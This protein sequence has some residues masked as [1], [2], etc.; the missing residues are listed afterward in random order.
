MK[1][2][3]VTRTLVAAFITTL[4]SLPVAFHAAPLP[5]PNIG[6]NGYYAHDKAQ[7]GRTLQAAIV[8]EIPGGYHV[9]ANRPLG[10]YAIPTSLKIDAP[11]GVNIGPVI[12]PRAIVRRL[13][14]VNNEPLAVYEGRAIL[15]FSVTVPANYQGGEV[16][17]KARLRYQSCND[18]VCFPPATRELDLAIAIV[19]R[20]TPVNHIN[21]QYFGGG[22][23]RRK[24]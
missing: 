10:K 22:G 17:L 24:G 6:V 11:R 14:A 15:R 2:R 21:G 19:G 20:D 5:E 3:N 1:I 8:M 9:N 13:K 12:Y 7:R 23:R 18:E 16:V 4:V